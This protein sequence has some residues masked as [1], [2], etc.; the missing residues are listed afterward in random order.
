M[1]L[2]GFDCPGNQIKACLSVGQEQLALAIE[3]PFQGD[4]IARAASGEQ[5]QPY[6]RHGLRAVGFMTRK[7]LAQSPN[8]RNR[9]EA[10][11]PR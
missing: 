7:H 2:Y 9:Q 6:D 8:F 3:V 4:D 5:Q 1:A 11:L 10:L